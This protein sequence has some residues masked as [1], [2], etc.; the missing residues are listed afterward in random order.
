MTETIQQII[1]TVQKQKKQSF[2]DHICAQANRIMCHAGS[3]CE[4]A[5]LIK[6]SKEGIGNTPYLKNS[7]I[8]TAAACI[9][10]IE[11]LEKEK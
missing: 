7:L 3:V 4:N 6:Y 5:D 11:E 8:N 1:L 9:R 10:M 2:P